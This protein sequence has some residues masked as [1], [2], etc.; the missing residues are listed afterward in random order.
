MTRVSRSDEGLAIDNNSLQLFAGLG[1][2]SHAPGL[3]PAI[4]LRLQA[5]V[6]PPTSLRKN[7]PSGAKARV[8]FAAVD[9]RAE[10]RTLQSE[11]CS[12]QDINLCRGSL[13]SL[14]LTRP[15]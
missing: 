1:D 9:V 4:I 5:G 8:D 14:P 7:H 10:A 6:E 12:L 15:W 13:S 3:K 2:A 11:A